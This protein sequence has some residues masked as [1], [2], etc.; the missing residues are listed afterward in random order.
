MWVSGCQ[1]PYL[2][3]NLELFLPVFSMYLS[4]CAIGIVRG[5]ILSML[6]SEVTDGT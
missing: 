3:R 4:W 6:R 2:R 5:A 1:L